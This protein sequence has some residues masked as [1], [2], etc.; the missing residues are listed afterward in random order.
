MFR[1]LN[2]E[3]KIILIWLLVAVSFL[4]ADHIYQVTLGPHGGMV[5]AVKPYHIELRTANHS[6]FAYL[7]DAD[8]KALPNLGLHCDGR[9]QYPDGT[10]SYIKFIPF[11]KDGFIAQ[12]I[13]NTYNSCKITM[14]LRNRS[15]IA[16]FDNNQLF[17]SKK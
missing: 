5:K 12:A 4:Y 10:S 1:K 17:V 14:Y 7:L 11:E 2:R 16:S 13:N 15:F 8:K 3:I 9:I 6:L